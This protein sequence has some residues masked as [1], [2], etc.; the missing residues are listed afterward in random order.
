MKRLLLLF[1]L[2]LCACGPG[3]N[4]GVKVIV[5]ARLKDMEHSVVI[6]ENGNFKAVGTQ[7]AV[8]VPKGSEITSGLGMTIEPLPEGGP[9]E[10]GMPASL[11]LKGTSDRVMRNGEW[12]Q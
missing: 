5:G 3:E 12:V 1:C 10:A 6:I 4:S 7:S 9:I 2:T 8:P 11:L